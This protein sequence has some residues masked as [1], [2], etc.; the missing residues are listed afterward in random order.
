[1][2][3][4]PTGA[5]GLANGL[6][7]GI[8]ILGYDPIWISGSPTRMTDRHFTL[9]RS[10]G[11]S[12]A[13]INLHP[14][15]SMGDGPAHQ[16]S[17]IWLHTAD[18][19]IAQCRRNGLVVILDMHE[20]T[21]M[22]EDPYGLK[23]IYVAAWRQLAER[24]KDEPEDVLFEILNEPNTKI[25]PEI[26]NDFLKEPLA[27]VRA[28]NPK[29][30]VIVGPAHWNGI[31]AL[32]EL[33]LPDDDPNILVTVH[34]YHP[35]EFSHQGA[36]WSDDYRETSGVRWLGTEDD[37]VR[38]RRDLAHGAEWSGKNGR[39]M[40]LGEF[41]A[42]ETGDLE[43]RVRYTSAVAREAERLGWSWS[44]WQFDSDFVAYDVEGGHWVEPILN[45]LIPK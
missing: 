6:G 31:D 14:F 22:A 41:G 8:N 42:L 16:L 17:E 44:Y 43:S 4:M 11:F 32:S 10:A 5:F 13:R 37:L 34:Y 21:A 15:K 18:W 7:R 45:A 36:H 30:T 27:L 35:M 24:Y 33:Q 23:P 3:D 28:S 40:H 20:F 19:A 38:L 39:P 9:I 26:W 2:T 12:H 29:R 25:T 1:M